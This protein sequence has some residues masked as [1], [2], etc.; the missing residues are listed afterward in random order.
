MSEIKCP[1]EGC[2]YSAQ[3]ES[4]AV[5]AALLTAHTTVHSQPPVTRHAEKLKRPSV[6]PAGTSEEW[7][8]FKIRWHEYK[9]GSKLQ[10]DDVVTQLLECCTE[11]LR[12]DLTRANRG[13]LTNKTEQEV[14][15]LMQALAV[16]K[17]NTMVARVSLHNM[18]QD[19]DETVRS[20]IARIKGQADI[21]KYIIKCHGCQADVDFTEPILQD[22]LAKGIADQEIQLDLLGDVNQRMSLEEMVEFVE[23]K[24]SG[25]RSASRL[26]D[27]HATEAVSSNYRRRKKQDI[28]EKVQE[29]NPENC[30]YCGG[31]G[32][33]KNAPAHVR[34]KDCPAFGHTCTCGRQHHLPNMCRSKDRA[35]GKKPQPTTASSCQDSDAVFDTLCT[36]SGEVPSRPLPLDHHLY[37]ELQD[38]WAKRRSLPQPFLNVTVSSHPEDFKALG[39]HLPKPS[40]PT[41][42]TAMADTGCQSCLMGSNMLKKLSLSVEDLVPV[43]LTMRA[44]NN[45]G[46]Q[47]LGAAPLRLTG[48]GSDGKVRETRQLV[49][50][51][52]SCDKAYLSREACTDLGIISSTFPQIGEAHTITDSSLQVAP[53]G[54]PRRT[55]PPDAPKMLPMPATP[56]NRVKLKDYLLHTYS[57]STFNTC[58]HQALPL[59]ATTPLRLR[60]DPDAQPVAHHT[61]LP[62]P[63]H[64]ED[65]V[66]AGLDQDVRLGVIE[67]VPIGDPVTWCHRMVVVPK[68]SGKPRRTVDFQSL[69]AYACR[70]THH[71]RSPFHQARSVPQGKLKSVFDAWNGYHSVPL[72]ENDRHYTTFITPWGRY[73][74]CTAPQ[75]YIASGDA[76]TRR[77]DE[78][79]ADIPN[80]TKCI[81][82]SLLWADTIEQSFFRAVRWLDICGRNG[83]ILNPEK[84]VFA[85]EEAEFAGFSISKSDVQPCPKYM[86]A[87]LDFPTPRSITDI[88]SWFGLVNQVSYS[89]SM[90]PVMLPFRHLLQK[91][92]QFVWT[93]E[94]NEIFEKSK[95]VIAEQ[96]QHGVKI[97]DK[98]RPTCLATDWS[99]DGIGFWLLQKHCQCTPIKPFCCH[100]GWKVT[101]VGSRFTHAA[102]T[103]YAPIEGEALAVTDAL[104]RAR[105]FV[106][107]CNDL[108]IAVDHKPLLKVLGDRS[109]NE[110]PNSRLRNLK[111]KTLRYRFRL[112]HI[113]GIKNRAADAMSRHPS[114]PS[115]QKPS[116]PAVAEL[117]SSCILASLRVRESPAS[118]EAFE[119]SVTESAA[120][121]LEDLRSVT[122]DRV[123]HATSSDMATHS[124]LHLLEGSTPPD[125]KDDWPE[126]IRGYHRLRDHLHCIDGVVMYK[127]RIIIPPS[128]R[129]EVLTA[130]HSAHQG[131]THMTSR[132]ESSVFWPGI[133]SDI[134]NTRDGCRDC[135]QNAPS[136]PHAPP[137]A[138]TLP[139][140]PFQCICADYF[141]YKGHYYLVIIDRYSN[142]PIVMKGHGGAQALINILRR[143]F[144]TYGIPEE[145]ASDGGPEFTSSTTRS[146]LR[147]WGVHHRLSSVAFPHSNTRA[148][149][150]VKTVKRLICSNTGPHGD[151]DT[152]AFQ[153]AILQY[154]NT[155][156]PATKLSPAMCVFGRPIKDFIPIMPGRYQPHATWR[157]TLAAREEALRNR[158]M[159]AAEYWSEHTRRLPPLC[160]GDPVRLQ[161]QTGPQPLKWDKTGIIIE[162]HQHDQYAV[163][164][165]GSGRVTLRN[166]KFLRSYTP[167][168]APRSLVTI[169]D[170]LKAPSTRMQVPQDILPVPLRQSD[171]KPLDSNAPAPA[172]V[173]HEPPAVNPAPPPTPAPPVP[174]PHDV[175]SIQP[176]SCEPAAPTSINGPTH[177]RPPGVKSPTPRRSGRAVMRPKWQADYVM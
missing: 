109:L 172:P 3:H 112:V 54:C 168:A 29:K 41:R 71:T 175:P 163:K 140:Y 117:S 45:E 129:L 12:K 55:L 81:D 33:G 152:D 144:V 114:G 128:L 104:D 132:A 82:D 60:V 111:E 69:N 97:F 93:E 53:C 30:G 160:V 130:L 162:V 42:I 52:E 83:I 66:K 134:Q 161:N 5:L 13:S 166:R 119:L 177:D 115:K 73:R 88:R 176:A 34:R 65:E 90:A 124:L 62:V 113:P 38:R 156:D 76:Y 116:S 47:I 101:L 4:T 23:A 86:R 37:N 142:W 56:E 118:H 58:P 137:V 108:I 99:K 28:R 68:A 63:V 75:G 57:S 95:K 141:T 157:D 169:C 15:T 39:H 127:D 50:I 94:L 10:G 153:R 22:I 36:V 158:H 26:L 46:I 2:E 98:S 121:A 106:L 49:Y 74:Y 32:H 165:D 64:W 44:A 48:V 19:R 27:T 103:R 80:K 84:F 67:P 70:E 100:E 87:I 18:K 89:F 11:D 59:M 92:S 105:Y 107:G 170:D 8:Y 7:Q 123:R 61:P 35:L 40:T 17:E 139:V 122:W 1:V 150:G 164:V 21:C 154:R 91:N 78:I 145:L 151:L 16:R 149:I 159:R 143:T 148:E 135:N 9:T 24:E 20:F 136:Q 146:F 25:K 43:T 125:S 131:V 171:D 133:T 31:T 155:P 147:N 174:P 173:S 72:H 120:A 138:P 126:L 51:S 85:Q 110:I 167:Y 102:E 6:G 14:L 79:V 77:Y 96:I